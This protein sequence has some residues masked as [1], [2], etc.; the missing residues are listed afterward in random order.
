[1]A[2]ALAAAFTT[3]LDVV[4]TH[5]LTSHGAVN[6]D[7]TQQSAPGLLSP[8]SPLHLPCISPSTLNAVG[9]PVRS[10]ISPVSPLYL[11]CISPVSPMYLPCISHVS[12]LYLP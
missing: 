12:P 7:G 5:T 3:P 8:R 4:V 9:S 10:C 6:A 11:P 2:G 1:M